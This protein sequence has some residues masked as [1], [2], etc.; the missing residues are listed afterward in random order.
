MLLKRIDDHCKSWNSYHEHGVMVYDIIMEFLNKQ[1]L[2][3][4]NVF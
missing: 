3:D 2:M 4:I 1:L